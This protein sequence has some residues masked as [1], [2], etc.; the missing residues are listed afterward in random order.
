MTAVVQ[1]GAE[2]LVAEDGQAFLERELEPVAAGDAVAGPVVEILVGDDAV[3]VLE[4]DVGG[5]V[6]ARQHVL[7]VEDV[8]A[9]VLHR[10]HVEV[11]DGDD[12]V[13]V[14]VAFEAEAFL[15]P[16]HGF[17]QRRHGVRALVELAR[18]DVDRQ[19]DFAAGSGREGVAQHIELA[20]DD[21]EQVGRL[22]ERVIP[23]GP[24]AAVGLVAGSD[25]VAVGEQH[26]EGRLV[27]MQRHRV[28]RHHVRA[29]GEPG[30]AAEALRLALREV[31]VLRAVEAGE[32]GV[33]V[34]VDADD[35]VQRERIGQVGD[36]QRRR[37]RG[38]RHFP[39]VDRNRQR[40][41]FVAIQHQR[42]CGN[43]RVAAHRQ[44]GG[45]G[46]AAGFRYRNRG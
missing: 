28:G 35:R 18:L 31:A 7:R 25:R 10:A 42:L 30:D 16:A 33:L 34:G 1:V 26:R 13:V 8:E 9:L 45:D 4:I 6:G 27:G 11:A 24:M 22:P 21:G 39:A 3:D 14:E 23:F 5:D 41:Q 20:G 38:K 40:F 44:R 46:G 12:H 43:G 37:R 15:V 36:G 29:V 2:F 19:L 32:A 17:L